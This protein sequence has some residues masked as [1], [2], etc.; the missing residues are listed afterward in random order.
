MNKI[1]PTVILGL[2]VTAC[3]NTDPITSPLL[4]EQEPDNSQLESQLPDRK[5]TPAFRELKEQVN[6]QPAEQAELYT[7]SQNSPMMVQKEHYVG[8]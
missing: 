3:S 8:R 1:L 4:P 2:F 6:T 5:H 7:P